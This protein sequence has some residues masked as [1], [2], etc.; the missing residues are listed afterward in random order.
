MGLLLEVQNTLVIMNAVCER[1]LQAGRSRVPFQM[2][3]LNL[4][5][6]H[7]IPSAALGPEFHLASNRNEYLKV[8]LGSKARSERKVDNLTAICKPIV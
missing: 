5:S 7:L 6:M 2:R 1:M 8:F 4:F 3:S